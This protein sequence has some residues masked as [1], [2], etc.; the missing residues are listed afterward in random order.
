MIPNIMENREYNKPNDNDNNNNNNINNN[1]N[2]SSNNNNPAA[3]GGLLASN[4]L[5]HTMIYHDIGHTCL[6]AF[7]RYHISFYRRT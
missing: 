6:F 5:K 7:D 3:A 2:N 1:S 4:P